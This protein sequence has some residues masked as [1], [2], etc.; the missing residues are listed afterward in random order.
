MMELKKLPRKAPNQV[1][2]HRISLSNFERTTLL[3]ELAKQRE[4]A[5]YGA[6][7]AQIGGILGSSALLWGVASYFGYNLLQEVKSQVQ[8]FVDNAS[9]T[10]ADFISDLLN[11]PSTKTTA[12]VQNV[13]DR[14]D[15]AIKYLNRAEATNDARFRNAQ[16][17]ASRNEITF[18]ELKVIFDEVNAEE[19]RLNILRS[20]IQHA[21]ILV[22][23]WQGTVLVH[24][25][26]AVP[27][28]WYDL[29]NWQ[30]IIAITKEMSAPA[31]GGQA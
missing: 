15:D 10:S 11:I 22:K 24:N 19:D 4:N 12:S 29:E 30:D 25:P 21:R 9:D 13:F 2:E 16:A 6:G 31:S 18:A 14:L 1:I 7:I 3:E 17:Q 23:Y 26:D 8:T 5:L 28:E 20:D 27:P